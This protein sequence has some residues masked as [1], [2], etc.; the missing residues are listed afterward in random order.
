MAAADRKGCTRR[1]LVR[2][3]QPAR[4]MCT[5]VAPRSILEPVGHG[6]NTDRTWPCLDP[7]TE[8]GHG[9]G[10]LPGGGPRPR[11]GAPGRGGARLPPRPA[12]RGEEERVPAAWAEYPDRL[13]DNSPFFH[14]RYAGQM[15]KPP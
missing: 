12:R 14:P 8:E 2:L 6:P 7:A 11:G 3:V 4:P 1:P 10:R 9:P 15:L 5:L 13:Q